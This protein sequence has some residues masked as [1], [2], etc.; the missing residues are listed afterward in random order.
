MREF[1]LIIDEALK[2]GLSPEYTTP[3]NTQVLYECLGFR[4]GKLGIEPYKV[5]TNPLPVTV[6]LLYKWPFPQ[7]LTGERYNILVVRDMVNIEDV[8]YLVSDDH[9]TVTEI[10]SIDSLTFGV[11]TLM[12]IADFGEYAFMTNGV[13]MIYWDALLNDWH[14]VVVSPTIPMMRT[15]CNFKGQ[16]VGGCVLSAWYDCDEGFYVWS[17]IGSMN[18]TPDEGGVA[19][20]RRDPYGG[21]V[22]H[23]RR[24]GSDVIGYSS[25]GVTL[26][27]PVS[28]PMVTFSFTEMS[29]VGLINR[30]A[31]GGNLSRQVY[32]GEDYILREIAPTAT[33]IE[34]GGIKELGYQRYMESLSGE[35]IIVS[36][37]PSKKNF[38]IGNS[39]KTFMLSPYG[40][41]EIPQHP[42]AVWRRNKQSCMLPAAVDTYNPLITSEAFDMGYRGQKTVFSTEVDVVSVDNPEVAADYANISDL[43][44]ST[45]YKP[46]NNEGIAAGI[47]SGNMFRFKLRFDQPS[48]GKDI[49]IS[50]IK[51]RYKMT[52]LRGLRGVH[53]PGIRGQSG[54]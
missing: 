3:L 39:S 28:S 36:Y 51:V 34:R 1:E 29:D 20:Y 32:V 52:D 24:F 41:T 47:I 8:V 4:C 45:I 7:F 6:D 40:L 22:Y 25:K 44:S 35:D 11:G 26:M 37:E 9:L 2:N 19:S 13:I 30:G 43:W 23:T 49:R 27:S 42:S 33:T 16:A 10:F 21:E 15:V 14:E 48:D 31:M 5:L 46:L 17:R 53:A 12:E 50:Y 38:Y 54:D 18:F